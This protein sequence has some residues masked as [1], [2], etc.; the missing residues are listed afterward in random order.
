[1]TPS[2]RSGQARGV[3]I[4]TPYFYPI[5]GGVESNAERLARY[6]VSQRVPVQVL[7]KRIGQGL[8][9]NEDRDGIA[10][11][12]IGPS[13]ERSSLG[14][15]L[16]TPA[17][18]GW[19]VR[20]ASAYDVVC[21][22]DY[23]ATGVAALLGRRMTGRRVVFQAQTTG[24]LSGDN[25]DPL[26]R[27]AGIGAGGAI[28]GA[29][30]GTIR[31]LYRGADAF[32]CISRDIE[33]ETLACGVPR[34][35]VWY[36]P[37]A[38]D[39][40]HFRPAEPGER[41]RLRRERN[42]PL[43]RVV[44]L[45]VGRLSREKGVMELL[46]AWRRLQPSDALL[47]IAGPDMTGH[48]WDAGGPG[49]MFVEQHGLSTSVRFVGPLAD[50]AP[51]IKTADLVVQPSHFEALGL[52]AI[53][54]LAC[55]VPLVAS[56]VGGLLDFVVDGENG[57]LCPPQDPAALASCIRP[58]LADSGARAQLASRARESVL[59]D[60]DELE[61]FGRMRTLFDRLAAAR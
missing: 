38:I 8:A 53:E 23:R 49:R 5:I 16:M 43:D 39:M 9:D 27:K 26:L 7:T 59:R 3:L 22:V 60:Y 17:I 11:H 57:R 51:M 10:I 50:V 35:R 52:S 46:E 40:T 55:G 36:L 45:F 34:E 30:K 25:V 6:L 14:K 13:G 44:C 19:L 4:L 33:R 15:W 54:A 42:L 31:A 12:R 20:H 29:V 37:N 61:V 58:L 28:A 2:T 32:A 24:V 41:D 47:V 1:M 21:C 18:V 48:P 56:A